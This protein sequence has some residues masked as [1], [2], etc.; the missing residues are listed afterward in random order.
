MINFTV[1][2]VQSDA[3]TLAIGNKQVPYFRTSEFSSLMIEN[4]RIIKSLFDCE[5]SGRVVFMTGSGTAS[6]EAS[7]MN[8]FTEKD[9]VLVVNGGSFGHRFVEIC[10][11]HGIPFEEIKLEYGEELTTEKLNKYDGS[12]YSGMI[13]QLCETSTGVLYDMNLVGEFCKKNDIF[14]LVD[15]I[16]GFMADE[17]SMKKF[18]VNAAISGSQKALGLPPGISIMVFDENAISRIQK[19]NVKSLYFNLAEYLKNMERGQTPFTPAVQI[20]I[21]LNDK[22]KRIEKTGGISNQNKMARERA[23][24]FRKQIENLPFEMFIP[25]KYASNCVTAL[26]VTGGKFTAK[27]LFEE[28]KDK[29]SIWICPNGGD[30]ADTV[31]RVGH[32]GSIKNEEI[33]ELILAFNKIYGVK[34]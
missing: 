26:K 28:L 13:L 29:Y 23:L 34:K 17:L 19:S 6:M 3:E 11:I 4:E 16:S 1:G 25:D 10:E 8:L 31:F 22:L 7:V 27:K 24:Y 2:P 12:K 32:I 15:A 5:E 21:Q 18:G 30:L 9:K 33:D 14:L 20:L